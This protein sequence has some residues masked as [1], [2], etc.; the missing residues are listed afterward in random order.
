MLKGVSGRRIVN[1]ENNSN[2]GCWLLAALVC[3]VI[4][5]TLMA[6]AGVGM[7]M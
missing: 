7:S 2:I 4:V 5:W 3:C 6:M 1:E